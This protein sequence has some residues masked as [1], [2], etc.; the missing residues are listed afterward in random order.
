MTLCGLGGILPSMIKQTQNTFIVDGGTW[1]TSV[2][3]I[4]AAEA[5]AQAFHLQYKEDGDDI[6]VAPYIEVLDV[7]GLKITQDE[8]KNTSW[9]Y[10]PL[11]MADAGYHGMSAS[12]Y[13]LLEDLSE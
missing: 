11:V 4:T 2:D 8:N 6:E 5:A 1:R 12:F 13:S 10:T 3:A 7:E 9:F